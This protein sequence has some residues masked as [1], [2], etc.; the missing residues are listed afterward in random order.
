MRLIAIAAVCATLSGCAAAES[1]PRG[2]ASLSVVPPSYYA[3]MP[4]KRLPARRKPAA[5]AVEA[6]PERDPPPPIR[7]RQDRRALPQG[8]LGDKIEAL[9]NEIFELRRELV[10]E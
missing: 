4:I 3:P 10:P 1:Q 9:Q 5:V 6:E 2:P 7:R 8:D